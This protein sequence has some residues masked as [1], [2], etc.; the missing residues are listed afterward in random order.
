MPFP[1]CRETGWKSIHTR[2]TRSPELGA[3]RSRERALGVRLVTALVTRLC[4]MN[5]ARLDPVDWFRR[6]LSLN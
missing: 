6:G 2:V 1:W 5:G 4:V 3:V